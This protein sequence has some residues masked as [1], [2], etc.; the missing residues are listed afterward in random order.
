MAA[1]DLGSMSLICVGERPAAL[2]HHC[3]QSRP[4]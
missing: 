4:V 3:I 1:H 2:S